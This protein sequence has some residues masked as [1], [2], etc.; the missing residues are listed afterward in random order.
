LRRV[1]KGPFDKITEWDAFK[2][3]ENASRFVTLVLDLYHLLL[4]AMSMS[5]PTPPRTTH[6]DKENQ[7]PTPC[8]PSKTKS[9]I[10]RIV[11]SQE[12]LHHAYTLQIRQLPS[13]SLVKGPLKSILK[14]PSLPLASLMPPEQPAREIT[15][16][17]A[18]PLHHPLYLNSPVSTLVTSLRPGM[19]SKITLT[20]LTEAYSVLS[21]RLKTKTHV[22]LDMCGPIPA[23]EPMREHNIDLVKAFHR[24]IGRAFVDPQSSPPSSN[25]SPWST[26]TSIGSV[27]KRG[28]TD[29]EVK[30]ARDLCN[31][32]HAAMRC[33]SNI[34]VVP[35]LTSV[36]TGTWAVIT[37]SLGL[38]PFKTSNSA[39][40]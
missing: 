28:F 22:M 14:K 40:S 34:S 9:R 31:L 2:F 17:P 5:L 26:P 36:F 19:D 21:A 38:M 20:D 24:D 35:V 27:K 8:T 29:E 1:Y 10:P 23:L 39:R 33:F 11:W 13:S 4:V 6:K 12:N 7:P 16:E 37:V 3:P 15:P 30:H 25:D 18:D 32:T